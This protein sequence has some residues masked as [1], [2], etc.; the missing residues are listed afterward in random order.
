MSIHRICVHVLCFVLLIALGC[1]QDSQDAVTEDPGTV[2]S[3]D[4]LD[5]P[6]PVDDMMDQPFP[7]D[8]VF[9]KPFR[10]EV[11]I[12]D[13]G[14][15]VARWGRDRYVIETRGRFAPFIEDDTL[16]IT[17]SY[18]GGCEDHEFTLVASDAF[19]ESYP[20]QLQVSLAH[21]ANNDL[22]R[23]YPTEA[24]AFDLTPIKALYR[25]V[26][27]EDSGTIVLL[28]RDAPEGVPDLIYEFGP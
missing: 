15:A 14:A 17:V 19:M 28:L 3:D 23:G 16:T 13:T 12:N 24:Y 22:C 5:Q 10:G 25:E 11:V 7:W 2:P 8:D 27:Q 26:Y 9:D 4:V 1:G 20:V 6:P 21:D 18:S